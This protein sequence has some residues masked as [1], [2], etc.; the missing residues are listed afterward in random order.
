[1]DW[2]DAGLKVLGEF[3][4]TGLTIEKLTADLKVTKGSFYHHFR[5]VE[6]FQRQLITYWG[7]QYLSTRATMPDTSDELRS[8]LDTIMQESFGSIT[9][10]EVSIRVWAHQDET[11]R[12]VVEQVD[13]I[14]QEFVFRVFRSVVGNDQSARVM[15]DMFS[16]MLVGSMMVLPRLSPDRVTQLYLEFK[17]LYGLVDG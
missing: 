17:R 14:R 13:A 1:M 6:D 8:L 7:D 4:L 15:T 5:N 3:G 10:P 2:F 11:V 12:S 16:A 9:E